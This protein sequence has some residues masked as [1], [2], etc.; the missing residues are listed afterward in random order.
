MPTK[1]HCLLLSLFLF[2]GF[3]YSMH[4]EEDYDPTALESLRAGMPDPAVI[5][6]HDGSGFYVFATG[7]GVKVFHSRDLKS[8]KRIGRVFEQHVPEWAERAVPGCDGIWAPDIQYFN[9]Q[10]HLYYSVSTFG[11]QRSVIGLATTKSINPDNPDYKWVDQGLVLESFPDKNDFN[12]IDPGV[13]ADRDGKTYLYW[14]SYW[15]GLKG[16]EI[17]TRTGKPFNNDRPYKSLAKRTADSNPPGIEAPYVSRHQKFYYLMASWDFCCA[18]VDSSYKV[19][20]GRSEH[21]LGPFRDSTGRDMNEG[22]GDVLLAS[23]IRWRGPGHNSFL[24]T[25]KGDF[26]VHHVYDATAVRKGRI[27]QVRP[28]HWNKQGWLE[29]GSPLN[30]PLDVTRNQQQLSK[31]VGSWKH[32]VNDQDHYNIFFE[33]SGQLSGVAGDAFWKLN[34]NQLTLRWLDPNAPGGAWIDEVTLS[35]DG[36]SYSGKNQNGTT[37]RGTK[38]GSR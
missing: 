25:P 7:H 13:L 27:L 38:V 10:Y 32:V 20:V 6:A 24:Q 37:I 2:S 35:A 28:V 1:T 16:L 36:K 11:S 34:A 26:I 14:G 18:G 5:E 15:N 17:N 30:D 9:N 33:V 4:A 3:A 23:G 22:G 19:V 29:I 12:A 21:P 31:L 8:W